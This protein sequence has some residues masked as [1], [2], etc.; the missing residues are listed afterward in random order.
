MH[1]SKDQGNLGA[2]VESIITEDYAEA[3]QLGLES[4][5]DFVLDFSREHKGK[6]LSECDDGFV[7]WLLEKMEADPLSWLEKRWGNRLRAFRDWQT[8]ILDEPTWLAALAEEQG[9]PFTATASSHPIVTVQA[10]IPPLQI[11]EAYGNV[12]RKSR[13]DQDLDDD[14]S[15]IFD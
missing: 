3:R 6:K 4:P 11:I 15:A 9:R 1:L 13:E 5:G 8:D 12:V 10:S 2:V 7:N 14:I